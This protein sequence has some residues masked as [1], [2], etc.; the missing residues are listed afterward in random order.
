M[1]KF[2]FDKINYIL[3]TIGMIII[4]VGFILMSG[5]G[6]TEQSF[7]PDI[8]SDTRIRTAPL[9]CFVG[10]IFMMFGIMHKPK[11]NS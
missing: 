11:G 6:S 3:L 10:F 2:A 4:I 7:N 1:E 9:V 5:S 8:F